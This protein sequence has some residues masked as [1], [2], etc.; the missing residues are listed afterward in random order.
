[1][2]GLLFLLIGG[3]LSD[4]SSNQLPT[5]QCEKALY[6]ET[7]YATSQFW[8]HAE[9]IPYFVDLKTGEN[10]NLLTRAKML[11]DESFLY[12]MVEMEE[13]HLWAEQTENEGKIYLD[14]AFE[15]FIDPD[16]D[17]L[18]Y[19]EYEVNALGITWDLLMA[20][21][22]RDGGDAISGYD[23]KGNKKE[24]VLNRTLNNSNDIDQSR[25]SYLAIPF[26][27][28]R[29]LCPKPTPEIG[30]IWRMNLVRVG[31]ELAIVEGKYI[32]TI[33]PDTGRNIAKYWVWSS[34]GFINTHMPEKFG[35]VVF[36]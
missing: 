35:N 5:Y 30:G 33:N 16:G 18:N 27:N 19:V 17:G 14:K 9:W 32:K 10:A 23:M 22:Y 11:W 13:P 24:I 25:T 6:A 1:M 2:F 21:P 3:F 7:E 4:D 15:L 26:E 34:H 12:I 31:W 36:I 20:K 8:S 28:F 29:G